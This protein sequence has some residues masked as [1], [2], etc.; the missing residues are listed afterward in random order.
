MTFL[1]YRTR[2]EWRQ[3]FILVF[4]ALAVSLNH[5]SNNTY[6]EKNEIFYNGLST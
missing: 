5:P 2:L 6:E 3:H 1:L 4:P